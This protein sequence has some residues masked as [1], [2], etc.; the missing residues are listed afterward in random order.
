M[1]PHTVFIDYS[2]VLIVLSVKQILII[3]ILKYL[4]QKI[5]WKCSNCKNKKSRF[6]KEQKAKDLLSHLGINAPF[7]KIPF[8]ECFVLIVKNERNY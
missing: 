6:L 7:S 2:S 3:L 8:V 4:E 1:R 5:Q